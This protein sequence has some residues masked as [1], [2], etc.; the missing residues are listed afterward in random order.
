MGRWRRRRSWDYDPKI[1]KNFTLNTLIQKR[2]ETEKEIQALR[3]ENSCLS[4]KIEQSSVARAKIEKE[5][6]TLAF[7]RETLA[8][9]GPKP[10]NP[11]KIL[12]KKCTIPAARRVEIKKIQEQIIG[13]QQKASEL[14]TGGYEIHRIKEQLERKELYLGRL[15][16]AIEAR[17]IVEEA[18]RDRKEKRKKHQ[19]YLTTELSRARA[20]AATQTE[21]IRR[22]AQRHKRKPD[23]AEECPYCGESLLGRA[24]HLDHIYPIAKGGRSL[25]TNMV[26]V[27]AECNT[28][29]KDMTLGVFIQTFGMDYDAIRER[30][31]A[32]NKEW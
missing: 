11:I 19:E 14:F 3:D 6:E 9:D 31:A 10:A 24:R 32:L 4:K 18:M 15:V 7:R 23:L 25:E 13:L 21:K 27:C 5:I 22:Q 30:L 28:K 29:K 8:Y 12:F 2:L 16:D 17:K 1:N 26:T 20:L